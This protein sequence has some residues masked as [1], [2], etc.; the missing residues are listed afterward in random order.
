MRSDALD[1]RDRILTI[2]R[3]ALMADPKASLLSIAKAA[4]VG[5]GTLYRHFPT[6][7]ALLLGVYREG[8]DALVNLATSLSREK[9]PLDALKTW[10]RHFADYGRTKHGIADAVR[11]A[12]SQKDFDETYWPM[13]GALRSL[14]D[15]CA[16]AGDLRN[17][18][19]AEDFLQF[20]AL[21]LHLPPTDEGI[22]REKRL[23]VLGFRGLGIDPETA[24]L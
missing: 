11:G 19:E 17:P 2:A 1:N 16:A 6:R 23:L 3:D 21:L 9:Q 10:C 4:G 5:Q 15:A 20:L 18:I 24:S 8:I 22:A 13:V 7:E 14:F 12:M